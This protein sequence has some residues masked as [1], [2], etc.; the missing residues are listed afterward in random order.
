MKLGFL[1]TI[2]R[3]TVRFMLPQ[4]CPDEI[5]DYHYLTVRNKITNNSKKAKNKVKKILKIK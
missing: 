4:D 5:I 3:S 2:L 1:D